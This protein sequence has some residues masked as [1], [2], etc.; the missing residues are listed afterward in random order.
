MMCRGNDREYLTFHRSILGGVQLD[1]VTKKARAHNAKRRRNPSAPAALHSPRPRISPRCGR[2]SG[3]RK[4]PKLT[5]VPLF[6]RSAYPQDTALRHDR[7]P[8][9]ATAASRMCPSFSASYRAARSRR[10]IAY[11]HFVTAKASDQPTPSP[12]VWRVREAQPTRSQAATVE[13]PHAA[14]ALT[15]VL[16]KR[17]RANPAWPR[18]G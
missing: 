18:D 17:R 14:H 13:T 12:T 15:G 6:T 9:T 1:L 5:V 8:S 2:T 11:R 16:Q 7:T 3:C 10:A 4:M